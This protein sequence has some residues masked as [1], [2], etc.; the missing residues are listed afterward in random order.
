MEKYT[1]SYLKWVFVDSL[2]WLWILL[3]AALQVAALVGSKDLASLF[4]LIPLTAMI[5]LSITHYFQIKK[6]ISK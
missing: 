2:Y 3:L 4:F 5:V 6:G 1:G